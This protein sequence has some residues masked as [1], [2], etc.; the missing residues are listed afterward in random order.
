MIW[1]QK[2]A[3]VCLMVPEKWGHHHKGES[4]V[5][6]PCSGRLRE[7]GCVIVVLPHCCWQG[8]GGW[9][10]YKHKPLRRSYG[11]LPM[12]L[13]PGAEGGEGVACCG[14][15]LRVVAMVLCCQGVSHV[16]TQRSAAPVML[17][18]GHGAGA[19][20]PVLSLTQKMFQL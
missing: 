18:D 7:G 17:C 13:F 3:S 10:S 4:A 6:L 14:A 20:L 1:C 8:E 11:T 2:H 12:L 5:V 15:A 19:A 16:N 9:F